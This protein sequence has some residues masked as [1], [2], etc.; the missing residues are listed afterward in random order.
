MRGTVERPSGLTYREDVLSSDEEAALLDR[1]AEV[2][3]GPVV[4]RGQ[5][6]RRTVR[7]YGVGYDF[8]SWGL[9]PAEPPP[10]YL[11]A[12]R[13]RC[14]LLAGVDA[15]R[16]EEVLLTRYPPGAGIGWHRDASAF[17]PV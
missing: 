16:F 12:L 5:A 10:A 4:V 8:D 6:A 15:E 3:F 14:A 17:G 1:F 7:H 13:D 9:T 11:L 2:S